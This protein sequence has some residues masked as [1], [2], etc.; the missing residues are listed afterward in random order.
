MK[1][2]GLNKATEFT[3]KQ[4]N[5]IYRNAKQGNLKVEKWMM[6]RMYDLSDYYGT[7]DDNSVQN[8]E[9]RVKHILSLVLEEDFEN[10]QVQINN[11]TEWVFESFTPWRQKIIDRNFI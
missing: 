11:L 6:N 2:Y 4:V 5:I 1:R 3:R 8:F 10:A 7:D 9:Q